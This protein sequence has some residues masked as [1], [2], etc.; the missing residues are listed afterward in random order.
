MSDVT[1]KECQGMWLSSTKSAL[2]RAHVPSLDIFY[3]RLGW[4]LQEER[5]AWFE[6]HLYLSLYLPI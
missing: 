3:T 6:H 1:A 2:D 4:A 5:F